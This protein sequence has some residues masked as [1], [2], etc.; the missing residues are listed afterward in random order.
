MSQSEA[1][2]RYKVAKDALGDLAAKYPGVLDHSI[3]LCNYLITSLGRDLVNVVI[4]ELHRACR[5]R[6]SGMSLHAFLD[7]KTLYE[8]LG[9]SEDDYL[10]AAK[11]IGKGDITWLAREIEISIGRRY[12]ARPVLTVDVSITLV[13]GSTYD[14]AERANVLSGYVSPIKLTSGRN[15]TR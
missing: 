11:L 7:G 2:L 6:S 12:E 14:V 13:F 4:E 8:I 10:E 5:N 1:Q 3:N 9:D 15:T